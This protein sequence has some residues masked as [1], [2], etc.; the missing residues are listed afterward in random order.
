MQRYGGTIRRQ[1]KEKGETKWGNNCGFTFQTRS[2][3]K[4]G[5]LISL[6][7]PES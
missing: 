3:R 2:D 5:V 1:K 4:G 7:L 6:D